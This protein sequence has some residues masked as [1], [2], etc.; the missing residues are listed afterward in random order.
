LFRTRRIF[1]VGGKS[2]EGR[3]QRVEDKNTGE[4]VCWGLG[5]KSS[6]FGFWGIDQDEGE[7]GGKNRGR[8]REGGETGGRERGNI[9][10]DTTWIPDQF[11]V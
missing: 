9:Y 7:A 5:E 1:L 3:K 6:S 4:K 11:K 8:G 2:T 10:R